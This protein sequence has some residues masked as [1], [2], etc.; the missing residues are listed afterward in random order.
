MSKRYII[1]TDGSAIS[2]N[3]GGFN[4]AAAYCIYDENLNIL[5]RESFYLEGKTNN[6]AEMYAIFRSAKYLMDTNIPDKVSQLLFVS[7][8]KLSVSTLC[9]WFPQWFIKSEDEILINSTNKPVINQELIKSTF[10]SFLILNK[11]YDVKLLHMK[12]HQTKHT[13][14]KELKTKST[15]IS[16]DFMEYDVIFEGND[17]CDK[18]AKKE[19]G[20]L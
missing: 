18:L 2:N 8:S 9:E 5:K 20:I 12:S 4:S 19:L 17:I 11:E 10:I 16:L 15:N 1:C 7:D 3:E 14:M 13:S 6:Y